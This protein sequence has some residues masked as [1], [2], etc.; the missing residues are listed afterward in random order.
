[1]NDL[2]NV[3]NNGRNIQNDLEF[4]TNFYKTCKFVFSTIDLPNDKKVK[5]MFMLI[6]M[7]KLYMLVS[8]PSCYQ[9]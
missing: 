9:R 1:M 3:F 5:M 4:A 6:K 2:K 7:A 8:S